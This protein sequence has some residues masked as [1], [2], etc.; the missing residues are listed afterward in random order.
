MRPG[1]IGTVETIH[2][3]AVAKGHLVH[4]IDLSGQF[5]CGGSALYE[6]WVLGLLGPAPGGSLRWDGDENFSLGT[7]SSSA[8]MEAELVSGARIADGS[9]YAT[10]RRAPP[11]RC[12]AGAVPSRVTPPV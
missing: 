1:E 7:A 5:R 2:R 9:V 4:H 10:A 11:S 8:G 3:H 6:Q 12:P